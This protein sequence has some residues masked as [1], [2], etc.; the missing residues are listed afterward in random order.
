VEA[1]G[2]QLEELGH[3]V[4]RASGPVD[5]G[6]FRAAHL[7]LWPWVLAIQATGFGALVGRQA[8]EDT[9]E[10]ASLACIRRGMELNSGRRLEGVCDPERRQPY[11]GDVSG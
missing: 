10:A 6:G 4:E 7:V 9:V 2:R 1:V 3:T 8:S 5:P 11:L